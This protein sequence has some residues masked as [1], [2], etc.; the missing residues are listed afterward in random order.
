MTLVAIVSGLLPERRSRDL[1]GLGAGDS[2]L[3]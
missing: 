1:K 2:L 3:F